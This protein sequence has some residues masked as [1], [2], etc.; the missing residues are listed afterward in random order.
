MRPLYAKV[1]EMPEG[2]VYPKGWFVRY[3]C[4][5]VSGFSLTLPVPVWRKQK[6]MDPCRYGHAVH[7]EEGH[8]AHQREAPE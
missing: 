2:Y 6:A 8:M 3:D 4:V 5:N 7:I 1:T